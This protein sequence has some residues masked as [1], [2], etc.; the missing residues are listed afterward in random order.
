MARA[1]VTPSLERTF[2][3]KKGSL[4]EMARA[5]LEN[6]VPFAIILALEFLFKNI[7]RENAV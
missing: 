6:F 4:L 5:V 7:I 1:W 3:S 2:D